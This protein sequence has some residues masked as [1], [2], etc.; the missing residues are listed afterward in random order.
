MEHPT[1]EELTDYFDKKL[2]ADRM[3]AVEAH[4]ASCDTCSEQIEWLYKST[5][6]LRADTFVPPPR[7]VRVAAESLFDLRFGQGIATAIPTT[8]AVEGSTPA[9]SPVT[10]GKMIPFPPATTPA[11]TDKI[12]RPAASY[13]RRMVW[14]G[15][16][17]AALLVIAFFATQPQQ[18]PLVAS[19]QE[20]QGQVDI[21][22]PN[23]S[24]NLPFTGSTLS[25][26][27]AIATG[28]DGSAQLVFANGAVRVVMLEDSNLVYVGGAETEGAISRVALA[29]DQAG[30]LEIDVQ[31]GVTVDLQTGVGLF[32]TTGGRYRF[33]YLEPKIIG[34]Q[35]LRGMVTVRSEFGVYEMEEGTDEV[36]D[37]T[38]P[39]S[40]PTAEPTSTSSPTAIPPTPTSVPPTA[41][42]LPTRLPPSATAV[43]SPS[44]TD[45][46]SPESE[47][48]G[49]SGGNSSAS[50]STSDTLVSSP[51]ATL[52]PAT[53]TIAPVEGE[54]QP[55][56]PEETG[57]PEAE[58]DSNSGGDNSGGGNDHDS[59]H[60]DNSGSGSGGGGDDHD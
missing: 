37:Y 60:D 17:V 13:W 9:P 8:T 25:E 10:G 35:V 58:G 30:D 14:I 43:E 36:L 18:G 29:T 27:S 39:V 51:T 32:T 55:E 34:V 3:M 57:E 24:F 45:D 41:T 33:H 46:D 16:A 40:T 1:W 26:G 53:A 31:S 50:G 47:P 59:E 2:S 23:S 21:T 15:G 42:A 49:D 19:V 48:E 5:N 56:T 11:E 20:Q 28:V 44:G 12:I 22:S 52:P 4:V 6:L 38:Q 7:R 54:P